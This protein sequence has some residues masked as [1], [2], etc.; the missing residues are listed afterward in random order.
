MKN[1]QSAQSQHANFSLLRSRLD[2]FSPYRKLSAGG[3][4]R[5][6]ELHVPRI[7]ERGLGSQATAVAAATSI[8]GVPLSDE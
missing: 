4:A 2:I 5:G 8:V 1:L 7:Y 3:G 6:L